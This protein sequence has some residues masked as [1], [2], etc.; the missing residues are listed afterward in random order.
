ME[1]SAFEKWRAHLGPALN[2]AIQ[3]FPLS[4][5]L[6]SVA[7]LLFFVG[8]NLDP[9]FENDLIGQTFVICVFA[10]LWSIAA[11]LAHESGNFPRIWVWFA[12]IM[13]TILIGIT[14]YWHE[15]LPVTPE[16]WPPILV[17]LTS[18]SPV[19]RPNGPEGA[20]QQQDFFWWINHRA[21][22]SALIAG[23]AFLV[24]LFGFVIVE[25]SLAILFGLNAEHVVYRYLLPTAGILFAPIFWMTTIPEPHEYAPHDL[26]E[27]DFI[28]RAAGF[29]GLYIFAPFLAFYAL[30]LVAYAVQ[31]LVLQAYPEGTV[32]WMVVG[33]I[34]VAGLNHLL[35]Y[36]AFM[37]A[38]PIVVRYLRYWPFFAVIPVM[39]LA[40]AIYIRVQNYGLTPERILLIAGAF[41]TAS[42]ITLGMLNRLDIRLLPGLAAILLLI[43]S[44]GPF[45]IENW[46]LRDQL[47]RFESGYDRWRQANNADDVEQVRSAAN[48]VMRT[49]EGRAQLTGLLEQKGFE[50]EGEITRN[51]VSELLGLPDLTPQG[52]EQG[53]YAHLSNQQPIN[54]VGQFAFYGHIQLPC[55]SQQVG[56]YRFSINGREL[57][58]MRDEAKLIT[59]DLTSWVSSLDLGGTILHD[60]RF[61]FEAENKTFL[62]FVDEVH[63]EQDPEGERTVS[64]LHFFLF[65]KQSNDVN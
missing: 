31:I 24:I 52:D 15:Q 27:P 4:V 40:V 61:Q 46:A 22:V 2:R 63:I 65:V 33:F 47:S 29:L 55:C 30:I 14:V 51:Q 21:I 16:I 17:L 18:I 62:G 20:Q 19:L 7:T 58:I 9:E 44:F 37:R 35:L 10:A 60:R 25:R 13:G 39:M 34:C 53:D 36:P 32:G 50:V 42:I 5:G 48:Y 43:I 49:P 38:N 23:L 45:N 54:L 56:P 11:Q 8:M 57:T 41:W 64:R 6:L 1:L 59:H 26:T 3:R 28:S 12:A